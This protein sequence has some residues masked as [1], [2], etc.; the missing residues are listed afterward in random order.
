M[1]KGLLFLA[2]CVGFIPLKAQEVEP[3]SAQPLPWQATVEE[4]LVKGEDSSVTPPQKQSISK[5]SLTTTR[6]DSKLNEKLLHK[7]VLNYALP[8]EISSVMD[9]CVVGDVDGCYF[10]LKTY[11]T[12]EDTEVAA[13]ANLELAILSLQR[14]LVKQAINYIEKAGEL[15]P[16][17]P[18]VELTHGWILLCSGQHKRAREI[19]EHLLYLTADFE[20]VSS[21]KLGTALSYYFS[22]NKEKAAASFQYVYTS[23]PYM[24]SFVSYMLGRIA[25]EMKAARH[26]A[27]VFLQQSLT[28]DEKNYAAA[29]LYAKLSEKKKEKLQAW[30]YYATLFSLDPQNEMLSKKV[31]KYGKELG[32]KTNDYLFYLRLEQ[33]IVHEIASVPSELVRI[34]LY[35]NR[36]QIPQ[37]VQQLSV[38][39]SG[40]LQVTDEKLGEVLRSPAYVEK[41]IAFN[42]QTKGIDFK[43][44]KGQVEF[45][46]VRPIRIQPDST[47]KTLLVKNLQAANLFAANW[48]D[49]ELKGTLIVIPTSTGIKL[50]NEV[51]AEDLIPALLAAKVQNI[52]QEAALRALAVVLRSALAA[53][54]AQHPQAP[55]HITDNDEQFSFKG[56]NLMFKGL[57]EAS[58]ESAQIHLTEAVA[59]AYESCGVVTADA[60]ENTE[61]KPN[62]QFSPANVSKYMLSNPPADLYARPQDPTQWSSVKW[63]YLYEVKDIQQRISYKK[64]IG[65]LRA[66]APIKFSPNGRILGMRFE[67]SKGSYETQDP[68]E[69][70]FIL[71]AGTMRSNFFDILPFY[72]GKDIQSVLVRGYD[73]GLG[74]GL[75]LRGA[76]GLAKTGADYMAIIKYYFPQ[77]RI[78]NTTTGMI[79]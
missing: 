35:A 16:E 50:T 66:I 52:T 38:M 17:D 59:G 73:T 57:I 32:D 39:G 27:P 11:E 15:A 49:K 3:F 1:K 56:I 63:I 45:S 47:H 41:I 60:I 8:V 20:Y 18:F 28:H 36:E 31:E 40:T 6:A 14:G 71:S 7:S 34:A 23:N 19:F 70:L 75:C 46:S 29:A 62:Y 55:Y 4:P 77:A 42:P 68:Q 65:A 30:Q 69:I 48:S 24:I 13:V 12:N 37:E 64:N 51:Y 2:L 33:P 43:N 79:N 5:S 10:S 74:N 58:Q 53:A 21:A 54:V 67:G 61:Q 44:A 78:I 25:S 72:K 76:E 26:L 22:G 9:K